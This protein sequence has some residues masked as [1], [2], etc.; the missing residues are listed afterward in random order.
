MARGGG[1]KSLNDLGADPRL[2]YG[3]KDNAFGV[4]EADDKELKVTFVGVDG[5]ELHTSMLTK[6]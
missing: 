1:G 3:L 6:P 5:K 2:I 4:L